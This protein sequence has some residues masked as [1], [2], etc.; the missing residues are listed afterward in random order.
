MLWDDCGVFGLGD[1]Y[2][3]CD[4]EDEV[5]VFGVGRG[6]FGPDDDEIEMVGVERECSEVDFALVIFDFVNFDL[7]FATGLLALRPIRPA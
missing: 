4:L 7:I 2:G 5:E 1:K 6:V 3:V